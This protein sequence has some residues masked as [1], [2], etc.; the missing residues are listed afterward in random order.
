MQKETELAQIMEAEN[1]KKVIQVE[2][3]KRQEEETMHKQKQR[4]QSQ[5]AMAMRQMPPPT[6]NPP[7][8]AGQKRKTLTTSTSRSDMQRA[9]TNLMHKRSKTLGS[10]S[11]EVSGL[12]AS[13]SPAAS[14]R[15]DM[16]ASAGLRR[17]LSQ[18]SLRQ[19]ITQQRLDQTHTDYFRLKAMGIDPE[20]PFVPDTAVSL[21]VKQ[22][23][24]EERRAEASKRITSRPSSGL[25]R[26]RSS[27]PA[28]GP[29]GSP[30]AP[31]L[32]FS[33]SATS[34]PVQPSGSIESVV[35]DPFLK[36]L[37]E[38]RAA[39]TSDAD[40]FKMQANEL[41]KEIEQQEEFRRSIGSNSSRE[42]ST[43]AQSM[44]GLT[45]S[46]SGH[47]YVPLQLK[48]GQ[49]LSRTEERIRRTGACGL[50]KKPVG[51]TPVASPRSIFT[52]VP[53]SRR[54]ASSL[55]SSQSAY[56]DINGGDHSRK[57]SFDDLLD[58]QEPSIELQQNSDHDLAQQAVKKVKTPVTIEALEKLQRNPFG[59]EQGAYSD[60]IDEE[61]EEE[62]EEVD[63]EYD[64]ATLTVRGNG[65]LHTLDRS[66]VYYGEEA[67]DE[68]DEVDEEE[69]YEE[70][71]S[72]GERSPANA[73]Y[74]NNQAEHDETD[75]EEEAEE[76]SE[77]S[78][79]P[80][81]NDGKLHVSRHTSQALSA[82]TPD[83]GFG[84]TVDDAIELS[85]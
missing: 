21:A 39:M 31:S 38:A 36:S 20:T 26:S 59:T 43:F 16:S 35:E 68:E 55:R 75:E 9:P 80:T 48:P 70:E 50:A 60:L 37:R 10:N 11:S 13:S 45:R 40:W 29:I 62:E 41:E 6:T 2:Q 56:K 69:E 1:M 19:S 71:D 42:D 27:T 7:Q 49:T 85:D 72:D 5:K 17:S 22:Q 51:L 83:T 73:R 74:W 77:E 76:G 65:L 78:G 12:S 67:D 24:E 14:P 81:T 3:K 47:G 54:T 58:T 46:V 63:E 25:Q 44:N 15:L 18:K 4:L 34:A 53:M 84:S 23:K 57:R 8:Q 66:G 61:E 32:S 82:A 33:T 30:A 79:S 64:E 28:E 52:A